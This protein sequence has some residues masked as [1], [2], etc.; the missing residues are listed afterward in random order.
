MKGHDGSV[1]INRCTCIHFKVCQIYNV[2]DYV[3]YNMESD[4]CQ[5]CVCGTW[6]KPVQRFYRIVDNE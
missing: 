1:A 5:S 3:V 2:I 6:N 4:S